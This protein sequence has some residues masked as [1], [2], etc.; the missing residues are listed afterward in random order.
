MPLHGPSALVNIV[1][2]GSV[3][4]TSFN[5]SD[6]VYEADEFNFVLTD[7]GYQWLT[8][9]GLTRSSNTR[10]A[11]ARQSPEIYFMVMAD[12]PEL[13]RVWTSMFLWRTLKP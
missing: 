13:I 5:P 12:P 10:V 2:G 1:V 9:G 8:A 3:G 11:F 7:P 6:V 4:P